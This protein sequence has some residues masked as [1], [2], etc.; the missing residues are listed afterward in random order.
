MI[1]PVVIPP[2]A[3]QAG[4]RVNVATEHTTSSDYD[5]YFSVDEYDYTLTPVAA[6]DWMFFGYNTFVTCV[7]RNDITGLP[8]DQYQGLLSDAPSWVERR[9]CNEYTYVGTRYNPGYY[10][11]KRIDWLTAVFVYT[12]P[13]KPPYNQDDPDDPN[14]PYK[15]YVPPEPPDPPPE[16]PVPGQNYMVTAEAAVEPWASSQAGC[17]AKATPSSQFGALGETASIVFSATA[18]KGWKFKE[19]GD[20]TTSSTRTHTTKFG[21]ETHKNVGMAAFFERDPDAKFTVTTAA[22]PE[23]AGTT[24]GG[25]EYSSGEKCTV[26]ASEKCS[27]WTFVEWVLSTGARSS[28]KSYTFTVDKDVTCTARFSHSSSG[29]PYYDANGQG[30]IVC[31]SDGSI[32]YDGKAV[33]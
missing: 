7:L 16:P 28:Q 24:S 19:W 15:P 4:C 10:E 30:Q 13:G 8:D 2:I 33:N 31:S 23:N 26:S 17:T 25:G 20:G 32:F 9:G 22:S 3:A 27:P 29:M 1:T 5:E 11:C 6:K 18:A 21:P 14:N 12:G